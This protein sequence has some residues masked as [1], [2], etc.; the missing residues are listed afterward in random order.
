MLLRS[1]LLP[2]P[3]LLVGSDDATT[4]VN[5]IL[6]GYG[7]PTLKPSQGFKA[8][9][10]FEDDYV[11]EYPRSWVARRNSL[12]EGVYIADFQTAD[13]VAV[14]VLDP[15]A[16]GDIRAA[17]VTA[18]VVPPG[19]Q[20]DATLSLPAQRLIRSAPATVDGQEYL[21]LQ[22]PSETTTRSGYNI[23]RKNFVVAGVKKDRLYVLSASARSDQYND[24]KREMLE[25]IVQSFRLR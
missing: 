12:R 5:S 1:T 2:L 16:D 15:P 7:L 20:E 23:K 13:K 25:R 18:A 10:E 21:Y 3:L 4:I 22:F 17:A 19:R 9:D 24:Q 8:Y 6:S 11:F 14:E